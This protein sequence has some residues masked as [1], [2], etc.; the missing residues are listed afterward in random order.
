MEGVTFNTLNNDIDDDNINSI[1][2]AC[3][4]APAK[5]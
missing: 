3:K 1:F 2:L 5:M 4:I